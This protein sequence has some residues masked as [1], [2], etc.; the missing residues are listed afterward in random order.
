[1]ATVLLPKKTKFGNYKLIGFI[2]SGGFSD[3]YQA[4]GPDGQK[5]A[6]KVL[7]VTDADLSSVA[8]R[9]AR[10]R[11]ILSFIGLRNVSKLIEA[12]LGSDRPWIASEYVEGETLQQYVDRTGPI[13]SDKIY[14]ITSSILRTLKE[15]HEIGVV[16]RDLSPSNI[17]LGPEGP[18]LIDFGTGRND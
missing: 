18:T 3:V 10:E 11:D 15:L 2:G 8:E 13:A 1:M 6:I 17:I 9:F 5:V 4:E 7:R 12:D 14:S 16:H